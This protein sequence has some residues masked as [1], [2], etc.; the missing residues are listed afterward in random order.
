MRVRRPGRREGGPRQR[1]PIAPAPC[2]ARPCFFSRCEI[3]CPT[4][5]LTVTNPA[6]S[7]KKRPKKRP[8][9][10]GAASAAWALAPAGREVDVLIKDGKFYQLSLVARCV[11]RQGS[12][13]MKDTVP[14]AEQS[15]AECSCTSRCKSALRLQQ[16]CRRRTPVCSH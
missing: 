11:S 10:S 9:T 2:T 16:P 14:V 12:Q 3:C 7:P 1:S 15:I 8:K 6:K 13:M 4:I 5:L